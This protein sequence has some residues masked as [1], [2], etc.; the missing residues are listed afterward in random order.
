MPPKRSSS[1]P[2][3][4][5][6]RLQ[7][8][9]LDS[10][11]EAA[12]EALVHAFAGVDLLT[13]TTTTALDLPL[14]LVAAHFQHTRALCERATALARLLVHYTMGSSQAPGA[15][16]LRPA[17]AAL[18]EETA[19]FHDE[20][21]AA[22]EDEPLLTVLIPPLEEELDDEVRSATL[23]EID[24]LLRE[25]GLEELDGDLHLAYEQ[26]GTPVLASLRVP[27]ETAHVW[28]LSRLYPRVELALRGDPLLSLERRASRWWFERWS[29]TQSRRG[30]WQFT[31]QVREQEYSLVERETVALEVP[32]LTAFRAQEFFAAVP[33]RQQRLAE[34]LD[35]SFAGIFVV[36][37]HESDRLV[38][39]NAADGQHYTVHEHNPEM[40]YQLG[41]MGLG[42]L[43]P[44]G[45]DRYLRSPGM[46]FLESPGPEVIPKLAEGLKQ[47]EESVGPGIAVETFL[48]TLTNR[49]RVPRRVLAASSPREAKELLASFREAMEQRGLLEAVVDEEAPD[50]LRA[51]LGG[52]KDAQFFR[53]PVD[54]PLAE[55]AGA[56]TEQARAA[57]RQGRKATQKK[58][59]AKGKGKK[60]RKR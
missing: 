17:R 43:L 57:E 34:M 45:D 9:P 12:L 53:M 14:D 31:W 46:A 44:F 41:F 25:V 24:D 19:R 28:L 42:R 23:T 37:E 56:L 4:D 10:E 52:Q 6:D 59:K 15:A 36:R 48:A 22:A 60:K 29:S 38:L 50:E 51:E 16:E 49:T 30:E 20:Q 11:G 54:E 21:E 26:D 40:D 18:E 39:E 33:P 27:P 8:A 47:V 55:W 5:P 3:P 13:V 1:R 32:I 35:G 7:V 58:G 2:R